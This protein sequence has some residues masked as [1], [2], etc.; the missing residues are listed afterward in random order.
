MTCGGLSP[1]NLEKRA[2]PAGYEIRSDQGSAGRV[3][4]P[5][6]CIR[7]ARADIQKLPPVCPIY[8]VADGDGRRRRLGG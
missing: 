4:V 6:L 2:G 1:T 8:K 3:V 7:P 5:D